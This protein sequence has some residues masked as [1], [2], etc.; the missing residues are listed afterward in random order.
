MARYVHL[1]GFR[2]RAVRTRK[3]AAGSSISKNW[4]KFDIT[5]NERNAAISEEYCVKGQ[6]RKYDGLS[7][8]IY[9]LHNTLPDI[10]KCI[11]YDENNKPVRVKDAEAV[12]LADAVV[13]RIRQAFSDWLQERPEAFRQQLTDRYNRLFNCIVR[14]RYDGSFQSFPGST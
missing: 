8:F 6:D 13:N 14:P 5:T 10:T 9:A 2:P 12:Q 7:L 11:G 4:T 1:C 3:E